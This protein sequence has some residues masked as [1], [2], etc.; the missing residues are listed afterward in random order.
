M[1]P[2]RVRAAPYGANWK[3]DETHNNETDAEAWKRWRQEYFKPLKF[4][5]DGYDHSNGQDVIDAID[6]TPLGSGKTST[7]EVHDYGSTRTPDDAPVG[8]LKDKWRLMPY[9]LRLRSLLTQ[10]IDS[11]DHFIEHEMQQIVQLPSAREI[12]SEHDPKFYLRYEACWV[13]EPSVE[14]DS[15]ASKKAT[16]FQC[17]LR[18]CTYSAPIYV[19]VRYTRAR[20]IVVKRNVII[21][22]IPIMLRSKKCLL[23]D[24]TEDELAAMKECP[25]DPGGYFIIKGVEKVILIQEQLSKNRVILEEDGKGSVTASITSSTHERKSKAYV[26]IK[27][28]KVYLKNNTLGDDIPIVVVFRAIGVET[29][30]EMVQLIGSEPELINA[31]ALSMEEPNRLNIKTQM[32]A[33]RYIGQKIRSRSSPLS[34]GSYFRRPHAPEDEARE[35]LANVVLSHIPVENFDF[36]QKAIY[37]GHV[38]RRVL[39][40]HLGKMPLDDK[41]YYGNKRL[42]LAGNLLSLLFEDLFKTF[43]KDLKRQADLVLSK[44]SRAQV[45][46]VTKTIRQDTITNGFITAIATGNWVLKRFRMDRAGVTQVLSR[47]SY[48]SA[49]GMMTRINSQFE[50]TRKV[51]GPRSLQPSQWGMLC[52]ADTPEGEA[53]GLVKNLALLAHITT[54]EDDT[55]PVERLCRDLGVEDV[56]RLTGHE[57]QATFI[58]FLN[59]LI[60]GVHS[61][62]QELVLDLRT[63]RRNG[64]LGEFV[65]VYLHEEQKAVH[66]ATDGG[67]VCR[68]L[69]IVDGKTRQPKLK[70]CHVEGLVLGTMT[71]QDLL[72]NGIV[73]YVDCNEENNTLIAVTERDLEV[74]IRQQ[75]QDKEGL[76]YTHLEV[77]PFTILGVVGGIIPVCLEF[78]GLGL[79]W[80]FAPVSHI[81]SLSLVPSS[82]SVTTKHIYRCHG[83]ASNGLYW[84]ERIRTNGRPHLHTDIPSKTNGQITNA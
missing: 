37:I 31:I 40:V 27:N 81:L 41:D 61:R 83:Q 23:R 48:M 36:R 18:D 43:N 51:S 56:K 3:K 17:R 29:D 53:C 71:I 44:P 47:L 35:V 30:M 80:I 67:R 75:G 22:R 38:V 73:E 79:L 11:F 21:G 68:P 32:Q 20:Q 28:D 34:G 14:E 6:Q 33:L 45:F 5:V 42:E 19:N 82:Q 77:D 1:K 54:G 12:R 15:Y 58:V 64:L 24:K 50:K 78:C 59:G 4:P 72:R 16:P 26:L 62:P 25:H 84:L 69:V 74:A 10:H 66:I 7:E 76:Q 55:G 9:F 70:Q 63:M 13:G 57:I 49:L 2:G 65:S 52:P 60:L 46:D 8:S 39:L